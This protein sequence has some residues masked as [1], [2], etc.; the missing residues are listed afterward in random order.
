MSRA[1]GI[2]PMLRYVV[3]SPDTEICSP[4]ALHNFDTLRHI[5]IIFGRNKEEDQ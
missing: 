3:I 4:C 2:P 5:L 1:R